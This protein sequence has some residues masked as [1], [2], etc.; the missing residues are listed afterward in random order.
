MYR[1]TLLPL[2]LLVSSTLPGVVHA[3][4]AAAAQSTDPGMMVTSPASGACGEVQGAASPS[5]GQEP[6]T[7]FDLPWT[8]P[9]ERTSCDC[10]GFDCNAVCSPCFGEIAQCVLVRGHCNAICR[11]GC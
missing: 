1:K 10:S 5:P 3:A 6:A 2:I 7:L 8:R 11:C 9:V 4:T